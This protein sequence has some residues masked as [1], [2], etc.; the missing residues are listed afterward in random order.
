MT[1]LPGNKDEG[2]EIKGGDGISCQDPI[3]LDGGQDRQ[4]GG[5][6]FLTT[7]PA[8]VTVQGVDTRFNFPSGLVIDPEGNVLVTD[9]DN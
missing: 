2:W 6:G 9:W 8:L 4:C 1:T 3:C 5:G 7:T